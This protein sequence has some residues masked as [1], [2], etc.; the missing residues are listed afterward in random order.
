MVSVKKFR[1]VFRKKEQSS[2]TTSTPSPPW[3]DLPLDITANILGSLESEEYDAEIMCK[4]AVDRSQGQLVD[5]ELGYFPTD[6][7]L[8]YIAERSEDGLVEALKRLPLLE[9]LHI[10]LTEVPCEY[11]ELIGRCCPS[12]K[13]VSFGRTV[14]CSRDP[15]MG[16]WDDNEALA[17]ART[18]P[19]LRHLCLFGIK[20]T[21]LGLQAILDGCTDLESLDIRKC[22]GI[23]LGCDLRKRCRQQLKSLR[24]P[25]DSTAD[26][27]YDEDFN[28]TDSCDGY[29][30]I[31]RS[32]CG[33]SI[34]WK[35]FTIRRMS[36]AC[37][38]H[39]FGKGL[40]TFLF[41]F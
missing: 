24:H 29:P 13:S 32:C 41:L 18:M 35:V 33:K 14:P 17:I 23:N 9:E 28:D 21:N 1:M 12:V 39:Q 25:N 40:L 5:I 34:S 11:I 37:R 26:Y 4:H 3:T 10:F 30:N 27:H 7:L 19:G 38:F 36:S 20:M 15:N 22:L 16:V 2:A 6:D 31:Y 8:G